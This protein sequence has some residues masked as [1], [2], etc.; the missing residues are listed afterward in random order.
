MLGKIRDP[1]SSERERIAAE[2][3]WSGEI[4]DV[5][6]IHAWTNRPVWPQLH[7]ALMVK[8]DL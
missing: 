4:G 5:G 3:I 2:I 6:E 7:R 1:A 8:G